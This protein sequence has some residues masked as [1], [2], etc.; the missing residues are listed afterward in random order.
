MEFV[1][2]PTF[3]KQINEYLTDVEYSNLQI[4]L[5]EAPETGALIKGGG[6]IRKIRAAIGNKGKSGGIR[7]IY[8]YINSRNQIYMLLAYPKS[9]K[10]NLTAQ[11]TAILAQ[12]VK[13][14]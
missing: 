7:V 10:D 11:E 3:T 5:S 14:I 1:E 4:L 6:G 13:D 2:T 12:L 8:Y 9:K